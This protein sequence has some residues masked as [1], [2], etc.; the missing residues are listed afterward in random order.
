M[1][2]ITVKLIEGV[3]MPVQKA[4]IAERLTDAMVSVEGGAM[5]GVTWCVI[6]EVKSGD[7]AIGDEQLTT[8]TVR[9]LASRPDLRSRAA[10]EWAT[11]TIKSDEPTI[12]AE[13][14]MAAALPS[15]QVGI[16]VHTPPPDAVLTAGDVLAVAGIAT[17]I[18]GGGIHGGDPVV[19]DTI[20][21]ALAGASI[22]ATLSPVLHQTVPTVRFET[23]VTVP[24]VEGNQQLLVD[25]FAENHHGEVAVPVVIQPRVVPP[26][27]PPWATSP[28]APA[29]ALPAAARLAAIAKPVGCELWWIGADGAVTGVWTEPG[30]SWQSYQ[31]AGPASAAPGGGITAVSKGADDME[32]WWVAPDGSVQGAYHA[33]DWNL[34]ALTGPGSAAMT[35]GIAGIFK[36]G[37]QLE[38]WWVA[39]DGSVQAA[40]YDGGWNLYELAAAGSASTSGSIAAIAKGGDSME[41]WWVAPD[42]SVQAAYHDGGWNLYALTGSGAAATTGGITAVFKGGDSMEVWWVAPDGSVA[43]A[44]H[45]ADWQTYTLSGP[46]SASPVCRVTSAYGGS[47]VANVMRVWWVGPTGTTYQGFFDSEWAVTPI[48]AAANPSGATVGVLFNPDTPTGIWALPDGS[49][50]DAHPPEITLSAHVS[51]GR[52]LHGT[53]WLTL[54]DDGS[55]R[56]TG[57]VTNDEVYGYNFALSVF[58]ETGTSADLGAAHHGSVAGW[59]EPGSSDDIWDEWHLPNPALVPGVAAYRF[60]ALTMS[61]KDSVD[62]VDYLEAALDAIFEAAVGTVLTEFGAVIVIGVEIGSLITTGSLVPG[63]IIAGGVPWL[64]GPAG[65]FVRALVTATEGEGRQLTDDEYAWANDQVFRGAL[66]SIDSFRITNFTGADG[67]EFTFPTFGGPTLVNLGDKFN[68]LHASPDT[69]ATVIH[70]LVH[71]CQIATS[72]DVLF[73]A[74][75][76]A[77]QLWNEANKLFTGDPNAVYDYGPAGFDYTHAW[78]EAQAQIV[79][80][81]FRGT[82]KYPHDPEDR[83][84]PR[85]PRDALSPYYSYITDNVRTGRY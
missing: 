67:R 81:W 61:L 49:L 78:F 72:Q 45:E 40:Y 30:T 76:I 56:W 77:T 9:A 10:K 47:L 59:G 75:A 4:Q 60:A 25:A 20:T 42:G 1:P 74:V 28:L 11:M 21:V 70:E 7:W 48:G 82:A 64:A 84:Y 43:G 23:T 55:T 12:S 3:F 35:A 18:P 24:A 73:T 41:V 68:D 14:A 69:E 22:E 31:L 83:G 16:Q 71:A 85:A 53:V 5:R 62:I 8:E 29:G 2:L 36:G 15:P 33:P 27:P 63:A 26:P 54:R 50:V 17:G 79:E 52:G 34:Y 51:G 65:I 37:S 6:E 46:G 38:V 57:D 39:P 58:A 19:I 66:P 44:Y 13:P 80:D 32:V